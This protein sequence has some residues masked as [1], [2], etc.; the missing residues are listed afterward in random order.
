VRTVRWL[1]VTAY[2]AALNAHHRAAALSHLTPRFARLVLHDSSAWSGS[3]VRIT[4]LRMGSQFYDP[5]YRYAA[6][7]VASLV[8]VDHHRRATR[9][10]RGTKTFHLVRESPT[11]PWLYNDEGNG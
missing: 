1:V 2:T 4:H 3:S 8:V 6:V 7:V 10:R 9:R 5:E 11:D